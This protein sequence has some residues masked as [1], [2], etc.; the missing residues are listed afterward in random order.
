M[1]GFWPEQELYKNSMMRKVAIVALW[2]DK[3][4]LTLDDVL[5]HKSFAKFGYLTSGNKL[6]F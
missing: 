3:D 4:N 5:L 6:D 2:D 1:I